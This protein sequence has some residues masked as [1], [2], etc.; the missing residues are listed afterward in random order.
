MAGTTPTRSH[1]RLRWLL[2]A[3]L[4]LAW[5]AL[6]AVAGP[7]SGKLSEVQSNSQ[8]DFLPSEAESQRVAELSAGF[9]DS[10]AFPAFVLLESDTPL[11]PAQ[12][13]DFA[14]FAAS[15]PDIEV[16]VAGAP[17]ERVGEFLLPGDIPVVPS[18][19][20]L[21]VLALL[22]FDTDQ[23]LETLAD[24]QNP[25]VAAVEQLRTVVPDLGGEVFLAGP[26]ATTA[27]LVSA[28]G[29]IDG[30]LLLVA[31][32]AV[33]V[34]LLVVYRSPVLPFFVLLTAG[35]ALTTA[36][37]VVYLLADADVV[38]LDGQGQGILSI[39]VVGAATDYSLLL[40][41]RY[42]EELR[43]HDDRYTAMRRAWRQTLEPVTASAATVVL[44]LLCLLLAD[45]G[46]TRGLG[47]VA[48]VG[49]VS[50]VLAALTFLPALLVL[51]GRTS[52]G[53]HGRWV[54]WPGVPQVGSKGPEVTGVWAKVA[55]L[56]GRRPVAVGVVSTLALL[57][58]AAFA[59]TLDTRGVSISDTFLDRVESVVG[60]EAL[61]R[62]FPAGSGSPTLVVAPES[63]LSVVTTVVQD[64]DGVSSVVPTLDEA[65]Q[66]LVSDGRVQ[67]EVTLVDA[68]DSPAAED[69]VA[70]LRTDLDEVDRDVVVGGTTA[71]ALDIREYS[72]ADR[73]RIIPVIL[74]MIFVVLAV[75]LRSLLAPLLLVVANVLSFAATLGA[76]SLV[77]D[78]VLD[79]PGGDPTVPLYAFVFL[80]A[81]GIDYSIFLM[82]RVREESLLQGTRPGV[83]HGLAV[84]G[85]VI[86][87]AGIVLAAT[88]AALGVLPIL[89]LLQIAFLVAFGVLLDTFVVRSLLVPAL[90]YLTGKRVWWPHPVSRREEPAPA[91]G[92][93][94]LP[95]GTSTR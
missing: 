73:D 72:T 82:T 14:D 52:P 57:V 6:S 89:F 76:A 33:L 68:A 83:L 13:T 70:A 17:A 40:V 95:T 45:I 49:I 9:S 26:A 48:A 60:G 63:E 93:V 38:T 47:P 36:S 80:V 44:G 64:A 41:A 51:P 15:V 77:F 53:Q 54:F 25:V 86:T 3:V 56:V 16:P 88:F 69:A 34:I 66:P 4:L 87:S 19:D 28:F 24:G 18:E 5:L 58:L 92:D 22:T 46:P 50:A 2:P 37:L 32:I 71:Q 39:L 27:D 62:H 55:R 84:T 94:L 8:S 59:P 7:Y 91:E 85:G 11:T 20:G 31:G 12:L 21:A 23:V 81:L 61:A 42:R 67:L 35:F 1:R 10:E 65:G 29:G 75:L 79:L 43:R 30:T 74:L 78:H 90:V